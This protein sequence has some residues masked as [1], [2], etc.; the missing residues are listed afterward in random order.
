LFTRDAGLSLVALV[1]APSID[2]CL[3][4]GDE[5]QHP[6]TFLTRATSQRVKPIAFGDWVAD[7]YRGVTSR[8]KT[9]AVARVMDRGITA[10]I[11]HR[12]IIVTARN[13]RQQHKA[14]D[15]ASRH[16]MRRH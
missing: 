3:R 16:V 6:R 11:R 8:N 2:L 7:N 4:L 9:A 14:E 12:S 15:G 13:D 10:G 1:D 5:A